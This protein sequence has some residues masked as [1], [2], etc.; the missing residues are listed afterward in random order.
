MSKTAAHQNLASVRDY[1]DSVPPMLVKELRQGLRAKL[2]GESVA[3]FHLILLVL[4]FP[5]LNYG[6]EPEIAGLQR[7]IWWSF[8]A[9]L[10]ILLPLRGLSALIQERR[11]NT[12]DTLLLTNLSTGRI[13]WG[14]WLAIAAQIGVTA[15]SFLP[16]AIVMYAAGGISLTASMISL[17]RLTLVA[18]AFTATCVALSWN[19]SWLARA[20]PALVLTWLILTKFTITLAEGLIGQSY[21]L[22]GSP[23]LTLLAEIVAASSLIF[24]VL[25]FAASRLAPWSEDHRTRPRLLALALPVLLPLGSAH[26]GWQN[27]LGFTA[28]I[29]LTMVSLSSLTEPWPSPPPFGRATPLPRRW[30]WPTLPSGWPHGVWWAILAWG[31]LLFSAMKPSPSMASWAGFTPR[32][33]AW[34]FT[35]RLLLFLLPSAHAIKASSLLA[36]AILFI[37]LQ[38]LCVLA[39][40]L[41][42]LTFLQ[43]VAVFIPSPVRL[44]GSSYPSTIYEMILLPAVPALLCGLA[45]LAMLWRHHLYRSEVSA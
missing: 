27:V 41:L 39:G 22:S 1:P 3:G 21:A 17:L 4:M 10:A 6:A 35:G 42:N 36:T 16:Y 5:A 14:K 13:V 25:E 9:V 18:L 12:L 40:Q 37:L 26:H 44:L 29:A 7:L 34:L 8:I 45:A 19:P 24:L 2:F 43:H 11:E 32:F 23:A 38:V 31:L 30:R 20:G 15:L 28:L 33:A